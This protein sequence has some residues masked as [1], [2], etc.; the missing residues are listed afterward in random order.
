MAFG[1]GSA[2]ST[3][4]FCD[5]RQLMRSYPILEGFYS[6]ED[7]KVSG[8]VSNTSEVRREE[9]LLSES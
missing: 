6:I 5:D 4:R 9:M 1:L 3:D 8:E 2:L 7:S